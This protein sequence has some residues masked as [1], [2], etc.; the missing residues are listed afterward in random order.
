MAKGILWTY[1]HYYDD[2]AAINKSFQS[3]EYSHLP[4]LV[5]ALPDTC[6]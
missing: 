1:K 2:T 6:A 5:Y 3:D 4:E